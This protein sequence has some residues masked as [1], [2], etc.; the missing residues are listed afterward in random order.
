[1]LRLT[2]E[3]IKAGIDSYLTELKVVKRY[4]E[5]TLLSYRTDLSEFLAFYREINPPSVTIKFLRRFTGYLSGLNMQ[6]V[7]IGRKLSALRGFLE[8]LHRNDV[9]ET[10]LASYLKNPK[11]RRKLPSVIQESDFGR[12]VEKSGEADDDYKKSLNRVLF[13]LLYGCSLRV[14]EV[15]GITYS[16]FDYYRKEV[17]IRG[18][19]N[20]LRVVPVSES[21]LKMLKEHFELQNQTFGLNDYLLNHKGRRLYSKYVYLIVNKYLSMIS[22]I[23]K[24]SPHVLRHSSA[25]HM[26]NNGADLLGIKE[27]LGHESLA[28]TQIY[29]QVGIERLKNVYKKSH[30]KS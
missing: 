2:E 30:P 11:T 27:I 15:C 6:P 1:M 9:I 3:Q 13:E 16:S 21:L 5:N 22:D 18:K 17:R 29:T 26:L 19:G 20:K 23:P 8:F 14:S 7:S 28:T 10:N 24:K 25:T 4:S 12:L